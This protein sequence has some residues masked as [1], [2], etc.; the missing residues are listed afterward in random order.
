MTDW[1]GVVIATTARLV[2][3]TFTT[4]DLPLYADL[5]A[6]PAVYPM[7]SGEP[8][9]RDESDEI[10]AWAQD[11]FA[12]EGIGLLAVE[13]LVDGAFVGM[14]GLHHQESFPDD[15]EVAWRL[16]PEHWGHGYATEAASA[17]LDIG[18]GA[19]GYPRIISVTDPDND[20]SLA[21]MNR[22]GMQFDHAARITD[23]G[24]EFD[25]VVYS[26]TA[27]RWRDLRTSSTS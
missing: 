4:D 20:R 24:V 16:A 26:I 21:V 1:D 7:L 3:R 8:L 25:G 27:A 6:H 5:N 2:L 15:V 19:K 23:E 10:A 22:L 13:R 11:V 14:C 9:T 12:A 17:W 18:F